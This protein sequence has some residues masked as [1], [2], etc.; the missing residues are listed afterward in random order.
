[1]NKTDM[2]TLFDYIYWANRRVL[3]AASLVPAEK[4]L[5]PAG[6]SHGSLRAALVHVLGAE[7]VWRLRCQAGVSPPT[8]PAEDDFPT[9][10]SLANRW[11]EEEQE[12]RS[13]LGGLQEGQLDRTVRYSTTK[14]VPYENI[15]WNLLV[16]VVNHGTQF[17]AE[18]AV[19]LTAYGQSPGDLDLLLYFREQ[20]Q[21]PPSRE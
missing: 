19:A 6:L 4:F 12:M 3:E 14:G 20:N 1:M 21:G 9:L 13:D 15:L 18:A 8:L 5:A 10:E 7:V 11:Q 17:R 2:L 16:H